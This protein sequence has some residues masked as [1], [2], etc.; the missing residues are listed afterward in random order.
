MIKTRT[1]ITLA[2]SNRWNDFVDPETNLSEEDPLRDMW[3]PIHN[4]WIGPAVLEE[5]PG[6]QISFEQ[7]SQNKIWVYMN[8][9]DQDQMAQYREHCWSHDFGLMPDTNL[10]EWLNVTFGIIATSQ[11]MSQLNEETGEWALW[12]PMQ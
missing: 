6:M 4:A 7:E 1:Y 2:D 12:D 9:V 3:I 8:F 10:L 5:F 11:E